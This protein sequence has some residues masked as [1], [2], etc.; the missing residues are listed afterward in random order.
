[1]KLAIVI[2]QLFGVESLDKNGKQAVILIP[3]AG[4]V[5]NKNVLAGTIA[6]RNGMEVGKTYLASVRE[7]EKS[8]QYGRQ[9]N[10]NK[11][12]EITNPLDVVRAQKELGEGFVYSADVVEDKEPA[13]V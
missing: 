9:F 2:C 1:M 11:V 12:M 3:V 13:S 10:W 5:P 8:E 4:S 6:E 7:T